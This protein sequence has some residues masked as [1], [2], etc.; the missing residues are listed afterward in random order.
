[1]LERKQFELL[2]YDLLPPFFDIRDVAAHSRVSRA[3]RDVLSRRALRKRCLRANGVRP[4]FRFRFWQWLLR[5]EPDATHL[6]PPEL[7]DLGERSEQATPLAPPL[8]PKRCGR[9]LEE[10]EH[11]QPRLLVRRKAPR[12]HLAE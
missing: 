10:H 4:A 1:M 9:F 8:C 2:L 3:W 12:S 11:G 5:V 6:A 7:G